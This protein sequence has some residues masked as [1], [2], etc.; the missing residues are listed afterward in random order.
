[1]PDGSSHEFRKDDSYTGTLDQTGTY[2]AVDGS[3]IRLEMSASPITLYLP[4]GSRYMFGANYIAHTFI[5]RHG[6]RMTYSHTN[7]EWTDTLG[8]TLKNP[9]PIEAD[10]QP[11]P[12][13]GIQTLSYPGLAGGPA[14]EYE[15]K[16]EA[17]ST[18]VSE[19]SYTSSTT[20][21]GN[22]TYSIPSGSIHLFVGG[23]LERVSRRRLA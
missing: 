19:L 12:A 6:N 8:R 18:Q 16:W 3:R 10:V 7:K 4:D 1:M 15:L 5:D 22:L 21:N 23:Y 20:C 13:P 9:L 11:Q 14:Q 2:L 17:L